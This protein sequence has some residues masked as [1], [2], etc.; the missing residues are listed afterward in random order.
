MSFRPPWYS[1]FFFHLFL[2]F[3]SHRSKFVP[4]YCKYLS[5]LKKI[6]L[7]L[8]LFNL[9]KLLFSKN[10]FFNRNDRKHNSNSFPFYQFIRQVHQVHFLGGKLHYANNLM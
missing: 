8:V 10:I 6:T 5:V 1:V 9:S 4:F 7:L 2:T 3:T